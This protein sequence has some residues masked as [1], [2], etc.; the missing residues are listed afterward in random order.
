[1]VAVST[2]GE[3]ETRWLAGCGFVAER[4]KREAEAAAAG[5]KRRQGRG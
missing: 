1:L 4:K 5:E 2:A 3:E